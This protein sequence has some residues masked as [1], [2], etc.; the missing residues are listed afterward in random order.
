MV[1]SGRIGAEAVG[2][3]FGHRALLEERHEH[4]VHPNE[5]IDDISH[6]PLPTRGR[7]RPLVGSYTVDQVAHN[8]GCTCETVE[9]R[10]VCHSARLRHDRPDATLV[11]GR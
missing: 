1:G 6:T 9:D 8:C 7:R 10:R 11:F 2:P 5:M 3:T 4:E